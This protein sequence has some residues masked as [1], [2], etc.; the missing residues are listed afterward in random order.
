M[1]TISHAYARDQGVVTFTGELDWESCLLL[2]DT[3][4]SLVD[5]YF[6]SKIELVITSPGGNIAALRYYITVIDALR[7]NGL[8]LRTRVVSL[9]SSAAAVMVCVAD[10]RVLEP[11]ARLLFHHSK[12]ASAE[13]T[14]SEIESLHVALTTVD[15]AMV[16]WL[17]DRALAG[18]GA[19]ESPVYEAEARDRRV[20]ELL[21]SEI[22]R[23]EDSAGKAPDEVD[24]LARALGE[25]VGRAVAERDREILSGLYMRLCALEL[26]VSAKL[27][28]TLCLID[29]IGSFELD[30]QP[31]SGTPGLTIP[32]WRVLFPPDGEVPRELLTRHLLAVGETGS[33]KTASCI[34]PVVAAMATAPPGRLAGALVIDP[35]CELG[36]A[37]EALAPERVHHLKTDA[38]VLNL[39]TGPRWAI[40]GDL[41][42]GRWLTA[43]HRILCRVASLEPTNPVKVLLPH[44]VTS[45]NAEFFDRTGTSFALTVLGLVLLL[46]SPKCPPPEEWLGSDVEARWFVER[47]RERALGF[48]AAPGPNALALTAWALESPLTAPPAAVRHFVIGSTKPSSE[49]ED[50]PWLFAKLAHAVLNGPF[51]DDGEAR[52]L[53]E[54]VLGY[55]APMVGVDG[56]YAGVRSTASVACASFATSSVAS[57]LYFGCEPGYRVACEFRHRLDFARLVAR[58]GPGT[59]LLFQPSRDGLDNLIAVGLKA[60]FFEAV[61]DDPDRSRGGADLPLVGYVADEFHRFV[62][63][64][65]LH[66]EQS[67][68]DTCRSFGTACV[69]SCQGVASIE[70]ALAHGGGTS[71]QNTSAVSILWNNTASKLVFRSTDGK[72]SERV[73][74]LAPHRPGHA[75]VVKVRPVSTLKTGE[76]YA[77]L[78][79]GRFERR[80]LEPYLP[81]VLERDRERRRDRTQAPAE[82]PL[83]APRARS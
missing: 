74:G 20:L 40:E 17:V 63:S 45:S 50:P 33:G 58:D 75:D 46:T 68:L 35:K 36:P 56:Q 2:V 55:W 57:A 32:S 64:D 34:Y 27:A 52:D 78:S 10:E 76:C 37:L 29:R 82:S 8:W 44:E 11:D 71:D 22:P 79:D 43:A 30:H 83:D 51:G 77:A 62:T 12:L 65:P 66:G 54:S 60:G 3:I 23:T 39:M 24:V 47:L 49:D 25:V 41:R 38:I 13:V 28:R 16:D 9:A 7:S 48:A 5:E 73:E 21:W 18:Q 15:R 53:G 69:L 67:F 4:E 59:L 81:E 80:Q 42:A 70:H 26:S 31:P 19:G 6:Y 1:A 14:A 61:L 72:T